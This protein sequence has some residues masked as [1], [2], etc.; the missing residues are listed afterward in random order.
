MH[1][2]DYHFSQPML[3]NFYTILTLICHSCKLPYQN[4]AFNRWWEVTVLSR[5]TTTALIKQLELA[6]IV[7]RTKRKMYGFGYENKEEEFEP[8]A[9][10]YICYM[11]RSLWG[12]LFY[13]A[14]SPKPASARM[15]IFFNAWHFC[16]LLPSIWKKGD[17]KK[18]HESKRNRCMK[19]KEQQKLSVQN[20]QTSL[21]CCFKFHQVI[22]YY[23]DQQLY[24]Q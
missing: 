19:E 20:A 22:S 16:Y 14:L 8:Q 24:T 6:C 21:C 12:T 9:R 17:L 11:P 5:I 4:Q 7:H 18:M 13:L 2:R 3:F 23:F 15:L 10:H 1:P